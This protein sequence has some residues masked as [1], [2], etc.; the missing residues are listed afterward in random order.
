MIMKG[1]M[2][3]KFEAIS[4]VGSRLQKGD[5]GGRHEL[6]GP[7]QPCLRYVVGIRGWQ[8]AWREMDRDSSSE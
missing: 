6:W 8:G 4:C 3:K 7:R 1:D 5:H 2:R